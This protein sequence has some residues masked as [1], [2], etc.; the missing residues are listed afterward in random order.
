[1]VTLPLPASL[2]SSPADAS[3]L[4]DALLF[5]RA[6][7]VQVHA[8]QGRLYVRISAQI[9]NEIGDYERL[10]DAVITLRN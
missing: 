8:A 3:R 10:A 6:I 4:R 1:M 2:G 7:E 5:D 9:Y